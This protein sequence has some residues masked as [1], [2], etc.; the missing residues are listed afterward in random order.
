M[1]RTPTTTGTTDTPAEP[2]EPEIMRSGML[3][4]IVTLE[5]VEMIDEATKRYEAAHLGRTMTATLAA[6]RGLVGDVR[7]YHRLP[8]I[9]WRTGAPFEETAS[10]NGAV[11]GE[12]ALVPETGAES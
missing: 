3:A 5:L 1:G 10:G 9:N 2:R 4:N 7:A 8:A 6:V 11:P 12:L